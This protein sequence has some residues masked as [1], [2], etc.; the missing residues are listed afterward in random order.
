MA[1]NSIFNEVSKVVSE[2]SEVGNLLWQ[3]GWAEMNAGN[4]SVNISEYISAELKTALGKH[5]AKNLM[6]EK[7]YPA[8]AGSFFL[9]TGTGKR[10]RDLARQPEEN[11]V[12]LH[13][14]DKGNGCLLYSLSDN[15]KIIE[16]TSELLTHLEIHEHLVQ[17]ASPEKAVLHTH[18][19]ELISITQVLKYCNETELNKLLWGMHPETM[20]LVPQG[21]GF[22]PYL[23]PGSSEIAQA[24]LE[25]FK[26]HKVVIWEKH[27]SFAIGRTASD[28]FDLIDTLSKSALIYFQCRSAGFEP[29]GLSDDKIPELKKLSRKF[30][31]S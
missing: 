16:P 7:A 28:A 30:M 23:L 22:L 25:K 5:T 20:I 19:T 12:V 24:S 2:L 8:L 11:A 3:K 6:F 29:E 18:A 27:G 14:A 9:V 13:V 10:M 15:Y 26:D 1:I 17:A 31:A 21:A 4:I